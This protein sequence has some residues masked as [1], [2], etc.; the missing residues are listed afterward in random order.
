M[1]IKCGFDS[2]YYYNHNGIIYWQPE[3]CC[4]V[5]HVEWKRQTLK[6]FE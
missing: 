1:K 2:M 5:V 6:M 4:H 3:C